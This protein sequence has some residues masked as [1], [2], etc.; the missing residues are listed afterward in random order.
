MVAGCSNGVYDCHQLADAAADLSKR[1]HC[2]VSQA[3][4]FRVA[5]RRAFVH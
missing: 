5:R 2:E 3:D 4:R 1:L